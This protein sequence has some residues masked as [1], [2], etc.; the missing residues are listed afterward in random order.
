MKIDE[1]MTL[2][3]TLVQ[4]DDDATEVQEQKVSQPIQ[5]AGYHKTRIWLFNRKVIKFSAAKKNPTKII[6]LLQV[7]VAIGVVLMIVIAFTSCRNN[8][9]LHLFSLRNLNFR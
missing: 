8:F 9:F 7:M 3:E 2:G 5:T 4:L 6:F 1:S